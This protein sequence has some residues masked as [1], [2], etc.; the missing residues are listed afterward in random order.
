MSYWKQCLEFYTQFRHQYFTTGSIWPSSRSSC[1][2]RIG[3]AAT[4]RASLAF[5]NTKAEI[6]ALARGIRKVQEMFR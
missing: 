1:W 4:A 2:R 3:S 5:Y 6:D